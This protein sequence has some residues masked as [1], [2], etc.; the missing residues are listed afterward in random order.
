L[1]PGVVKAA[2]ELSIPFAPGIVTP[3][4]IEKA[5]ELGCS[6]LK[7]FPAEASGGLDYLKS[8]AAPYRHLSLKYI[9]LG[10]LHLQNAATYLENP[11]VL[12]IGGSWI[13]KRDMI[14]SRDWGTI[15]ENARSAMK[16]VRKVRGS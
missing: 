8:M 7:F 11:L 1:N 4:D 9:P 12:A 6:T 15:T 14:N 10:G 5:V 13:A 3:S 2:K 16:L